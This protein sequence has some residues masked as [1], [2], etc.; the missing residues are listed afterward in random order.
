MTH[1][2]VL[3]AP[4]GLTS[5]MAGADEL[6]ELEGVHGSF[7]LSQ[8]SKKSAFFNVGRFQLSICQMKGQKIQT[9]SGVSLGAKAEDEVVLALL[10]VK[11]RSSVYRL[12]IVWMRLGRG[13]SFG[14]CLLW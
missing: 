1:T 6:T 3:F 5:R 7:F 8:K 10:G 12:I 9:S 2:A 14:Y 13:N 4:V 11:E